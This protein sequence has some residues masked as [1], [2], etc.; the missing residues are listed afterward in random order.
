MVTEADRIA[1]S[2]GKLTKDDVKLPVKLLG[3]F[4]SITRA[5]GTSICITA[6]LFGLGLG[7]AYESARGAPEA[8][9]VGSAGIGAVFDGLLAEKLPGRAGLE[10]DPAIADLREIISPE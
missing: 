9:A 3:G 1:R 6:E 10:I 5:S 2:P 8:V 7:A 4:I